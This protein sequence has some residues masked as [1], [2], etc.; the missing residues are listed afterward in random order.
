MNFKLFFTAIVLMAFLGCQDAAPKKEVIVLMNSEAF[1]KELASNSEA[2]LLDVRTPEEVAQGQI[3]GA[4]NMCVTCDGFEAALETLNADEPV[5]V[6][7]KVGGRSAKASAIMKRLGFK[8][9][10]DLKGG[11]TAWKEANL[12]TETP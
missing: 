9:V 12:P 8:K 10:Y 1:Q 4:I 5:Y 3:P 7:C 11:Y 2:Q 6:Y